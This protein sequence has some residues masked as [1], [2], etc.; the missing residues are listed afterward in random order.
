[1]RR[2]L[3]SG[4][5]GSVL[6]IL[7][8]MA[9]RNA[10]SSSLGIAIDEH[11]ITQKPGCHYAQR[12]S[13]FRFLCCYCFT[14]IQRCGKTCQEEST[15][16]D[17]ATNPGRV[18]QPHILDSGVSRLLCPAL[19]EPLN[20]A[21]KRGQLPPFDLMLRLTLHRA[22]RCSVHH[23]LLVRASASFLPS[24]MAD[25]GFWPVI[26]RPSCTTKL[27]YMLPSRYSAPPL[28]NSSCSR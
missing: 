14:V 19:D 22:E 9:K 24:S 28:I 3:G 8:S 25:C 26:R 10:K 27:S 6:F 1:M 16:N 21:L 7:G 23:S 20:R 18:H 15:E 5:G 17:D 11:D 2:L 13:R 12:C 4:K